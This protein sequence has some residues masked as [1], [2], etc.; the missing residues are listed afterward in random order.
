MG[1]RR[2]PLGGFGVA[3]ERPVVHPSQGG[4]EVVL[5]DQLGEVQQPPEAEEALVRL[6]DR[7]RL[8]G[9]FG[10]LLLQHRFLEG[11]TGTKHVSYY[12]SKQTEHITL[13]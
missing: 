12:K 10:L 6:E 5:E 4:F 3:N 8:A 11:C 2:V 7:C 13:V 1:D 9:F